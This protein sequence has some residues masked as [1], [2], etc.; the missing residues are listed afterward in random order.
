MSDGS[1]PSAPCAVT[2]C[3]RRASLRCVSD[4][5][6]RLAA[7]C[8]ALMPG[9]TSTAMPAVRQAAISSPARPKIIGS[10]PLS[11]TTRLPAFASDTI[12]ALISSCL[13]DGAKPVLPTSIFFASR[14]AKSRIAGATRSSIRI[15][16]ADCSARTAR[17]V[18]NSGSPGPA[19]TSV[20]E[21]WSA[22]CTFVLRFGEQTI[23]VGLCRL[24]IGIASR[25][26]GEQLPE[27]PPAGERQAR[28]LAPRRASAARRRP[29]ARS[30]AGSALRAW[31]GS[32]A[33]TPA[34]RRRSKCRSPAASG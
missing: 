17:S 12:S 16:S 21:P 32:P 26:R 10:P 24:A 19:P 23:E 18:S 3:T 2:Y 27:P 4:T 1:W 30:R 5:P 13:Q 20:T 7:P 34:P 8:A 25:A 28:R 31:R 14:R 29:S 9:T 22:F 11:R 33:R 6:S 15:T